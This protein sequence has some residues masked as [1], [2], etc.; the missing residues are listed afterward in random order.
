MASEAFPVDSSN[1]LDEKLYGFLHAHDARWW[2]AQNDKYALETI[3][4]LPWART[5][6]VGLNARLRIPD[7]HL[8]QIPTLLS[9][10]SSGMASLTSADETPSEDSQSDTDMDDFDA[11][12]SDLDDMDMSIRDTT[13]QTMKSAEVCHGQNVPQQ[14]EF[15]SEGVPVPHDG[16]AFD[17][18]ATWPQSHGISK[19]KLPIEIVQMIH[20]YLDIQSMSRLSRV[21]REDKLYVD[22]SPEY[23]RILSLVPH[24][25][26]TLVGMGIAQKF[27][28]QNIYSVL[29]SSKC[30]EAVEPC[31]TSDGKD[32]PQT[33]NH[34]FA[35]FI[36]LRQMKRY[37]ELCWLHAEYPAYVKVQD[38]LNAM[39]YPGSAG[40]PVKRSD[41]LDWG[42]STDHPKVMGNHEVINIVDLYRMTRPELPDT[43][44]FRRW[45]N[46]A[47]SWY[48]EM[49]KF[50]NGRVTVRKIAFPLQ[51]DIITAPVY[52]HRNPVEPGLC[53]V[54]CEYEYHR[55]RRI[56][57]DDALDSWVLNTVFE[58][59]RRELWEHAKVCPFVKAWSSNGHNCCQGQTQKCRVSK[60]YDRMMRRTS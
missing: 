34:R 36:S 30:C 12:D 55:I 22:H 20:L 10:R 43:I 14:W 17:D 38:V 11:N 3:G 9:R 13:N 19:G 39:N 50:G 28:V 8:P 27:S 48:C 26:P 52:D 4:C 60:H 1:D 45:R 54:G 18:S 49:T 16:F 35:A 6:T 25:P 53:C 58:R 41:L 44:R 42:L 59:S 7:E 24:L 29:C 37:C 51:L 40:N 57:N 46:S 56:L 47:T 23:K 21:S 2:D 32:S 31:T 15:D 33:S 5:K